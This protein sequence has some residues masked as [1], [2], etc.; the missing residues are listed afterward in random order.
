MRKCKN[1]GKEIMVSLYGLRGFCSKKCR[2]EYRKT[3]YRLNKRKQRSKINYKAVHNNGGYVNTNLS[4]VHNINQ[5]LSTTSGI[6]KNRFEIEFGNKENYQIAKQCCNFEIKQKE[7]YCMILYEPYY[8][9]MKPCKNCFLLEFLKADM[10]KKQALKKQRKLQ[11]IARSA[12]K[13]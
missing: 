11:E 13:L 7:G 3:Y 12:F 9:F 5:E 2:D 1:C 10:M 6:D 8:A 4:D